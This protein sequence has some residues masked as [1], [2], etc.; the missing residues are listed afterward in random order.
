MKRVKRD[1]K[2]EPR[3]TN[4]VCDRFTS[5]STP[6]A[7]QRKSPICPAAPYKARTRSIS[8]LTQTSSIDLSILHRW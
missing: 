2:S 7:L 1:V 8:K 5:Y 4:G 3:A 6:P